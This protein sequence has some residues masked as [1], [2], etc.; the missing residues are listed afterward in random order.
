MRG[1]FVALR[2]WRASVL[3]ETSLDV[4]ASA[5]GADSFARA[6]VVRAGFAPAFA[7]LGFFTDGFFPAAVVAESSAANLLFGLTPVILVAP[8]GSSFPLPDRLS[9]VSDA[10][11]PITGLVQQCVRA[12]TETVGQLRHVVP[13]K[14]NARLPHSMPAS[15]RGLE[16]QARNCNARPNS[17]QS[18]AVVARPLSLPR[19]GDRHALA[20][21][22]PDQR[23]GLDPRQA[24]E[25]ESG[26]VEPE[27][28]RK[29]G[30]ERQDHNP[31]ASPAASVVTK[32]PSRKVG[33]RAW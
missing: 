25:R 17:R 18:A 28:I 2:A 10:F 32:Q 1:D 6:A 4:A 27:R 9:A 26:P 16:R 33:G 11:L 20:A 13:S 5:R 22:M 12:F 29:L 31:P 14:R 23:L 7:F 8:L 30:S 21:V 3:S 15:C 24:E 19:A